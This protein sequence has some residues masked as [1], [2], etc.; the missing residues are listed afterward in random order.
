[1][2]IMLQPVT[3]A[4]QSGSWVPEISRSFHYWQPAP[5]LRPH[6]WL[7]N[8]GKPAMSPQALDGG[9]AP[10]TLIKQGKKTGEEGGG[11]TEA[12]WRQNPPRKR[13]ALSTQRERHV[14]CEHMKFWRTRLKRHRWSRSNT[15][16]L[17]C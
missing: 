14:F 4:S 10:V 9:K 11:K 1:M 3:I 17:C 15:C 16:G 6:P 5:R 2:H 13:L 8:P 7:A 12:S